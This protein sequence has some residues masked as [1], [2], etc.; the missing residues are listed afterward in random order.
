MPQCSTADLTPHLTGGAAQGLGIT[1]PFLF[2][3]CGS[4]AECSWFSER[5]RVVPQRLGPFPT[6]IPGTPHS[7][8]PFFFAPIPGLVSWRNALREAA[9]GLCLWGKHSFQELVLWS[10]SCLPSHLGWDA[11]GELPVLTRTAKP[12]LVS[13]VCLACS[14]GQH[15]G[16]AFLVFPHVSGWVGVG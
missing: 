11:W 8:A 15:P 3:G 10:P 14:P 16:C 13:I 1:H 7:W 4:L 9:A 6:P 5:P 2:G 12:I